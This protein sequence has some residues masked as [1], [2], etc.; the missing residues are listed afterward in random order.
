M[1]AQHHLRRRHT[2]IRGA[3]Y[4]RGPPEVDGG[5]MSSAASRG[6]L[7]A[8]L[9]GGK[10]RGEAG[11]AAGP[12]PASA[13]SRAE[14]SL[15]RSSARVA[16]RSRSIRSVS[17]VSTP[18][19]SGR[20]TGITMVRRRLPRAA[21]ARRSCRRSRGSDEHDV[22]AGR[23]HGAGTAT[24]SQPRRPRQTS[25]RW[26]E[27][28]TR[29][30]AP[31]ATSRIPMPRQVPRRHLNAVTGGIAAPKTRRRRRLGRVRLRVPLPCATMMPTSPATRPGRRAP[32]DGAR[33]QSPSAR[34]AR[35]PSPCEH[36]RRRELASSR[37]TRHGRRRGLH[38]HAAAPSPS[39]LPS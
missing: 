20:P 27:A 22:A 7:E 4:R 14:K 5:E 13:S 28:T 16:A 24:P 10:A 8:G 17:T 32:L 9:P 2:S 30:P 36:R 1:A 11:G 31:T 23:L 12:S 38:Q 37:A 18:H 39:G 6:A 3:P 21:A 35:M 19:P 33:G 26:D 15:P 34:I 25:P 29:A